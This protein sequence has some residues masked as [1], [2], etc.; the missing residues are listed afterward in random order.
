MAI[1]GFWLGIL[2]IYFFAVWLRWLP[3]SGYVPLTQDPVANL[4]RMILPG[5]TVATWITVPILRQLRAT[6]IEVL[7]SD[8]IRAAR[9]KGVP[10]RRVVTKHALRN[11]LIPVLTVLG[12]IVGHLYSGT[13]IGET[14]FSIPG[15]GRLVA[16]SIVF[17]DFPVTQGI[18]LLA[19][20]SVLLA[21]L[22]TDLLYAWVDPRIRY[23]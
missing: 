4:Q 18:V 23:D 15:T 22:A 14:I 6:L 19:A 9:A 21:N 7:Q 8:Y 16:D 20:I 5:I 1:P 11:A 17:R 2:L 12:G 3:P 13:V 10:H